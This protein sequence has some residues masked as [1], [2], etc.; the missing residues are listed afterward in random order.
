MDLERFDGTFW[1]IKCPDRMR[2]DGAFSSTFLLSCCREFYWRSEKV[3]SDSPVCW[4]L[5]PR[6]VHEVCVHHYGENQSD[7]MMSTNGETQKQ[8]ICPQHNTSHHIHDRPAVATKILHAK[9]N[10]MVKTEKFIKGA[11]DYRKDPKD[12]SIGT[13]WEGIAEKAATKR[14]SKG[15][16]HVLFVV[17]QGCFTTHVVGPG[18]QRKHT[19]NASTGAS[20][21]GLS[22]LTASHRQT[23][24]WITRHWSIN[25]YL[26]S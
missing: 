8:F 1:Q 12:A 15:R 17:A 10:G 23:Q 25:C 22:I 5:R 2:S 6:D 21:S 9:T 11:L 14:E 24:L 18:V 7:E 4:H 13:G 16:K 3:T 19:A 26:R 20:K